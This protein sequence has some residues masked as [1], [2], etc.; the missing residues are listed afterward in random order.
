[1][2]A[3]RIKRYQNA[4]K[5]VIE[6]IQVLDDGCLARVL[7]SNASTGKK[8]FIELRNPNWAEGQ[9]YE[10]RAEQY[11]TFSYKTVLGAPSTVER[12]VPVDKP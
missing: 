6:I 3:A 4:A 9:R 12:W 8:I 1:M 11:G 5:L 7:E 10:L 2:K